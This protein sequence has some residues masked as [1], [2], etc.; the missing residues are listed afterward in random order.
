MDAFVGASVASV[1]ASWMLTYLVHSTALLGGAALIGRTR[2]IRGTRG[3][4]LLWRAAIFGAVVSTMLHQS[5]VRLPGAEL[6]VLDLARDPLPSVAAAAWI[7][8]LDLLRALVGVDAVDA[9]TL[10]A[11]ACIAVAAVGVARCV[12]IA[13]QYAVLRRS[14]DGR[15]QLGGSLLLRLREL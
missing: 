9:A 10:I 13:A 4:E 5:R 3:R 15:L 12:V 1:A 7:S 8:M 14:L 11:I 2:L 6:T